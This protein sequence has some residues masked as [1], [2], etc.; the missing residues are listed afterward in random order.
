[1]KVILPRLQFIQTF[2]IRSTRLRS[3][4]SYLFEWL[5]PEERL[6]LHSSCYPCFSFN[7]VDLLS[8]I[9]HWNRR[10][11]TDWPRSNWR[12]NDVLLRQSKFSRAVQFLSPATIL[13]R[14]GKSDNII[15]LTKPHTL[16]VSYR[17]I[18]LFSEVSK[19][20]GNLLVA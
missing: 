9:R 17:L 18:S 4:T 2:L 8:V 10:K 5:Q 14:L 16:T 11:A 1:M 20:I 3:D 15:I 13:F 19:I 12:H 6:F 7:L